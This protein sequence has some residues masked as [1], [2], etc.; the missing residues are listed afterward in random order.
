M[1][2]LP[3]SLNFRLRTCP[4]V[5]LWLV[6][7][8]MTGWGD[9]QPDTSAGPNILSIAVDE[10]RQER[11]AFGAA[12]MKTPTHHHLANERRAITHGCVQSPSFDPFRFALLAGHIPE[13]TA[14]TKNNADFIREE[15]VNSDAMS[16]GSSTADGSWACHPPRCGQSQ[17]LRKLRHR[18]RESV[19][20]QFRLTATADNIVRWR[21]L[22]T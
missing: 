8:T 14:Y 2:L 10:L 11:A 21:G 1:V 5:F 13:T 12:H 9:A 16:P 22:A 20:R 19:D 17:P 4:I 18:V 15:L 3:K 7:S 6:A